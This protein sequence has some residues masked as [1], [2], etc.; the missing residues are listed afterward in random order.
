MVR[1]RY[2]RNRCVQTHLRTYFVTR[3]F[4]FLDQ[5]QVHSTERKVQRL[6]TYRCPHMYSLLHYKHPLPDPHLTPERST[7]D[8]A[9]T[10]GT[11]TSWQSGYSEEFPSP[12]LVHWCGVFTSL[13]PAT[14]PSLLFLT[15]L[16]RTIL[17]QKLP[18]GI[19]QTYETYLYIENK[20]YSKCGN[21]PYRGFKQSSLVFL[22]L[23][24]GKEPDLGDYWLVFCFIFL[25]L[26]R[27]TLL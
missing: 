24:Y 12:L 27:P 2:K 14:Q 15:F 17:S 26:C 20:P 1:G 21:R 7:N 6:C 8:P 9:W 25:I 16:K 19:S 5:F 18:C 3:D 10:Q 22:T 11:W 13:Q 4:I 23:S